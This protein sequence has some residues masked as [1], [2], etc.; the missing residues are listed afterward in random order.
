MGF[1]KDGEGC[2]W[3]NIH[4]LTTQRSTPYSKREKT[5]LCFDSLTIELCRINNGA[6]GLEKKKIPLSAEYSK[7]STLS[8]R[9]F[10]L[11]SPRK[12]RGRERERERPWPYFRPKR[13]NNCCL[14]VAW[15][16]RGGQRE[17]EKK[18]TFAL[19]I[20]LL[21]SFPRT[22][23]SG[24]HLAGKKGSRATAV[25]ILRP[26]PPPPKK[27]WLWYVRTLWDSFSSF[28][29]PP[30]RPLLP[31]LVNDHFPVTTPLSGIVSLLWTR[32]GTHFLKL[33]RSSETFRR[34]RESE[35]S[36]EFAEAMYVEKRERT[37]LPL[38]RH[39]FL[40][41]PPPRDSAAEVYRGRLRRAH[42]FPLPLPFPSH[43]S[44]PLAGPITANG[45][46]RGGV[47][48]RMP[49]PPPSLRAL[50]KV[51]SL[52][53]FV[54]RAKRVTPL[55]T[56]QH[57]RGMRHFRLPVAGRKDGSR[58]EDRGQIQTVYHCSLR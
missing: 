5:K 47:Q 26:S 55:G 49:L 22:D 44:I 12:G 52:V 58:G 33:E 31:T 45:V 11:P 39:S 24:K 2:S 14:P 30:P 4:S 6:S 16:R 29:R 42:K 27:R 15:R 57:E 1:D 35:C 32:H 7:P 10:A 3:K 18:R 34:V 13:K 41:P 50:C 51:P 37:L 38:F 28:F 54:R 46:G 21:L 40:P 9:P 23:H 53:G 17:R 20:F 19:S 48:K 25:R 8:R 43:S 36:V 56:V